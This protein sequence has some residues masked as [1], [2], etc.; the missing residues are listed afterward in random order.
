[1]RKASWSHGIS[2]SRNS[3]RLDG[4]GA[5][6]EVGVEQAGPVEQVDLA[7]AHDVEHREQALQLDAGAGFLVG[8]AQRAFGGRLAELHEAGRQRPQ[9]VARLDVAAAQQH[10]VAPHRHRADHVERVFVVDGAAGGADRA[11]AVVVGGH[12]V[13]DR[14]AAGLAVLDAARNEHGGS[15]AAG[16]AGRGRVASFDERIRTR[17]SR[18]NRSMNYV[19]PAPAAAAVPVTG[20]AAGASFPVHRI[21]CVGRNYVEH[22]KEMGYTGREPPFFFMKPAERCC[23]W[24]KARPAGCATRA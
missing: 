16:V 1:M 10:L 19:L 9:A 23:R 11:L 7:D 15:V 8:L 21:Y 24:P 22:A 17:L 20:G 13:V 2:S 5:G 3:A 4:L 14:A 12:L 6:R 18:R